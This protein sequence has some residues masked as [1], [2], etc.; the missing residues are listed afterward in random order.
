MGHN[1]MSY[2]FIS[3][4]IKALGNALWEAVVCHLQLVESDYFDLQYDDTRGLRVGQSI[5]YMLQDGSRF[6][7]SENKKKTNYMIK[8]YSVDEY[9]IFS[10]V[11]LER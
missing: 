6:Y 4:Q 11:P 5:I 8:Y 10:D 7:E 2:C 1:K 9:Y 3:L